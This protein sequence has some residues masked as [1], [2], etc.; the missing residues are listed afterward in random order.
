M[1]LLSEACEKTYGVR[2]FG[3]DIALVFSHRQ[4]V[5]RS[6][7]YIGRGRD[8]GVEGTFLLSLFH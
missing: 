6:H 3:E 8:K 4:P 5:G 7:V 1:F 2:L